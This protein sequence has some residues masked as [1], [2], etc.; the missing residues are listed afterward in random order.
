MFC[1]HCGV[2]ASGNYCFQC[3]SP[4]QQLATVSKDVTSSASSWGWETC[5]HYEQILRVPAVREV[6]AAHAASATKGLSAEALLGMYDKIVASP[7]PLETVAALVQPIYAAWGVRT[8]KDKMGLIHAPIGRCIAR[9]LCSLARHRQQLEAVEQNDAGCI[10]IAELPSSFTAFQG[11]IK[12]SLMRHDEPQVTH[13]AALTNIPGQMYDWGKSTRCL[14]TLFTD[15]QND[16]GLPQHDQ[17]AD[18]H[19]DRHVA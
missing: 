17:P 13:I 14:D 16:M 10:L 1:S 5:V 6:V 15:L 2:A 19:A 7:I 8:G 18:A 3:G 11:E 12:I 4:L 9:T